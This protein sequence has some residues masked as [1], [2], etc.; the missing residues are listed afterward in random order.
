[1]NEKHNKLNIKKN[2]NIIGNIA[3][4][5]AIVF[6]IKRFFAMGIDFKMFAT[7][8]AIIAIFLAVAVQLFTICVGCFPW[9]KFVEC[10]SGKT[11]PFFSAMTVYTKSNIYKYLPGN[12]FQYVGRN[13]LA[14]DMSIS[15]VDVACSTI[16]DI[17]CGVIPFCIFSVVMLRDYVLVIMKDYWWSVRVVLLIGFSSLILLIIFVLIFRNKIANYLERYKKIFY[18]EN[19]KRIL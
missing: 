17:I 6:V 16:L 15:N 2:I 5:F 9:L 4:I 1:M 10:F 11:I 7:P 3:V 13:K 19:K 8:K 14:A 18:K 12:V